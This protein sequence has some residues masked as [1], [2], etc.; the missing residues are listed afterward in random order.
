[1]RVQ[2]V[3]SKVGGGHQS[4]ARAM[5]DA[6]A[7][8]P[9]VSCQVD[10]LYTDLSRFPV[11]RFPWM[12]ATVTRRY[13]WIWRLIFRTT[14]RPPGPGRL[15]LLGDPLGGPRLG[16][17]LAR[18]RP[19]A[20]VS[21]LPGVNGFVA[22]ALARHRL[23]ARVEVV[24]TDWADI[25]LSWVSQ[26]VDHY[27]VPTEAAAQTCRAVGVPDAAL[28]VLG[29]PVRRQF[30]RAQPG[31][32]ARIQARERLGLP[33]ERFIVLAMVGTEGS[34]GAL[35]HLRGLTRVPLDAD[36]VAVCGRNERLR[37][38]VGGL[39]GPNRVHALGFV[40]GIVDL[41]LAADL[42]VTK[43]GGVTL[44]E[45]FCCHLP[46]ILFDPL[47][48]QEEANTAYLMSRGAAE[49]AHSP[50]QLGEVAAELRWASS[51]RAEL[52]SRGTA[53]ARPNAAR[54]AAV[55]IVRRAAPSRDEHSLTAPG[56]ARGPTYGQ[57]TD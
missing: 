41:M 35:A 50:R 15:E 44:A 5:A 55:G 47:P 26:N 39:E 21:V 48:G 14:N 24:V 37:R 31:A 32:A 53:L 36:I 34:S 6:F 27:T 2:I 4:V 29:L 43:P 1:M 23:D 12:Y 16:R 33:A 8:L 51:R 25:H 56:P 18:R 3:S 42:L 52:A 22:R 40:E 49:L 17:L 20:V 57:S 45:A 7:D 28:S 54:D 30:A 13:P 46:M 19:E 10:D 11:S 38:W 9:D